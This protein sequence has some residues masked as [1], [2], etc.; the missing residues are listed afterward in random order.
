MERDG[1]TLTFIMQSAPDHRFSLP[2]L[3]TRT[4][5]WGRRGGAAAAPAATAR[6]LT[7]AWQLEQSL[8][9]PHADDLDVGRAPAIDNAKRWMDQFPE[10]GLIEFGHD[11]SAIG[12]V[13]KDLD[14]SQD[15]RY[16]PAPYI[17]DTLDL[18]PVYEFL[19]IREGGFRE[20][21]LNLRHSAT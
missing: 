1:P 12:K 21:D 16:D 6:S 17:P 18:V 15:L 8:T 4:W 14:S 11:P 20:A 13:A 3:T 19:Q 2:R 7:L 9:A 10:S 5:G